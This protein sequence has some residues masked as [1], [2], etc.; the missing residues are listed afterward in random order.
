MQLIMFEIS[1]KDR[2]FHGFGSRKINSAKSAIQI[3]EIRDLCWV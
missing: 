3:R 2:G 1:K